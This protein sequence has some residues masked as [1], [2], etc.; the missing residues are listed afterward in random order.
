M[1]R[2]TKLEVLDG[3]RI[4]AIMLLPLGDQESPFDIFVRPKEPV[5]I[6]IPSG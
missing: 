3:P 6:H 2:Y 5:D 1:F 4:D